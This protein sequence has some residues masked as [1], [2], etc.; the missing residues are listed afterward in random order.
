[1]SLIRKA[2]EA[3]VKSTLIAGAFPGD[4][5]ADTPFNPSLPFF[6]GTGV[7]EEFRF[8][9]GGRSS[10]T[11]AY[12]KCPPL[13]AIINRKAQAHINARTRILN[14]QG[15]DATGN[16][17][18]KLRKLIKRPNPLQTW[19]Q[20]KAQQK[21]YVQLYGFSLV[22][23]IIP[24]GYEKYG[25]IEATSIWN[26]PPYLL[27]IKERERLYL[28]AKNGAELIEYIKLNYHGVQANLDPNQV[29]IFK[30]FTPSI[31]TMLLPESRV[32]VLEMPV[33]NIIGAYE[34]K[35]V[36][37][38][39]RGAL[40]ILSPD[41]GNSQYVPMALTETQKTELQ[42]DFA[43]YG[44]RNGQW[45][46]IVSPTKM[47]WQQMGIPTKDLLLGEEINE[48]TRAICDEYG[49]PP[50]LLGIIDPTFNNQAAAEK[51]LYQ[52]SIIPEAES[53]DEEWNML[54][55]TDEYNLIMKDD[56][57]HITV[58]QDDRVEMGRARMYLNQ[59]LLIEWQNN[60]ITANQWLEAN[61]MDTV[62]GF[63]VYYDQWVKEGKTF[64]AA[65]PVAADPNNTNNDKNK[66]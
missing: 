55:R 30:D 58:L 62:S 65:A 50:H 61:N 34:S 17:A 38:N 33:N 66:K 28:G 32:K 56:F 26:I 43:R 18:N 41:N 64:G 13:N 51:G 52:N 40:G 39:L 20:F 5:T 35:N 10:A 63:D 27:D 44:L 45:K 37:I 12:Q 25:P 59:A 31:N 46:F 36:L 2:G 6:F 24:V 8:Q 7:R 9:Y 49:Y 16:D 14:T 60:L 42:N 57:Q 11:I 22:L 19:K 15:K 29:Y 21:I 48:C 4:F 3:V 23:P 54:F 47:S 1:M 53:A